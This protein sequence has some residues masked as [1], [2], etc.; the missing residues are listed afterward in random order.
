MA[1]STNPLLVQPCHYAGD[2]EWV[3]DT[4]T[5][6]LWDDD[7]VRTDWRGSHKTLKGSQPP[8]GLQSATYKDELWSTCTVPKHQKRPFSKSGGVRMSAQLFMRT[9]V[10]QNCGRDERDPGPNIRRTQ[11][12]IF[13]SVFFLFSSIVLISP[14]RYIFLLITRKK[15]FN[16]KILRHVFRWYILNEIYS[17]FFLILSINL[18]KSSEVYGKTK[19]T[20]KQAKHNFPMRKI[21]IL[22]NRK[23]D[24]VKAIW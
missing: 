13:K 2:P 8:A 23:Q 15:I 4:E 9:N 20:H 22:I 5:S 11:K 14:T 3:S 18:T 7:N 17:L 24:P 6:T 12:S 1:Y 16:C 21:K 19:A 10:T